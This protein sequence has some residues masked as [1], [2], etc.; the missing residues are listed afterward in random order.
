MR[1]ACHSPNRNRTAALLRA[2]LPGLVAL[3]ALASVTVGAT[4]ALLSDDVAVAGIRVTAGSVHA[5]T[6]FAVIDTGAA[7]LATWSDPATGIPPEGYDIYRRA[8]TGTYGPS[9]IDTPG[10]SPWSDAT[11]T[12]CTTW[13][14]RAQARHT[15]LVSPVTDE[16]SVY[17]DRTAPELH[18][19]HAVWMDSTPH[20]ADFV[21][22]NPGGNIEVYADVTDNCTSADQLDVSFSFGAPFN[23]T[24]AT[25]YDATGWTPIA[26]GPTYHFRFQYTAPAYAFTDGQAVT[27]SVVATDLAGNTST[28]PGTP[29]VGDGQGPAFH[30]AQMVSAYTNYFDSTLGMGEIPSDGTAKASGSY[31]YADFTDASGVASVSADLD[32]STSTYRL[33]T[34]AHAVALSE[35]NFTTYANGSSWPWRSAATTID[36]SL[37]DGVRRFTVTATDRVGNV[38]TSPNQSVEI[39]DTVPST[40]GASCT[41]IAGSGSNNRFAAGDA[42]EW[43]L[44]DTIWPGALRTNWDGSTLTADAILRNGTRDYFDLNGDFG[45]TMFSGSTYSKAWN[46]NGSNWVTA[47]TTPFANSTFAQLDRTTVRLDYQGATNITARTSSARAV[48]SANMRDAAGN[49]AAAA[50]TLSCS[51]SPW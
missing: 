10:A 7:V 44:G 41:N 35:G 13:F 32:A 48:I 18:A 28:T 5:P 11:A 6:N 45:L 40:T 33:K 9:P 51:T 3:A 16:A 4:T 38:A 19:G 2:A 46:L 1:A 14:Y 30:G 50:Y 47:L 17:V 12:E 31:V 20:V 22:V 43:D 15:N 23:S 42:T 24:T 8:S 49:K 34:G 29:V 26:G 37:A 36:T 39:D 27:W 21:R 25:E